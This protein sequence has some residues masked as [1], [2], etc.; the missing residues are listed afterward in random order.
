MAN[1]SPDINTAIKTITFNLGL[2]LNI[3]TTSK[4]V[5]HKESVI[6]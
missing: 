2:E 4:I 5:D 6:N 3:L 1:L